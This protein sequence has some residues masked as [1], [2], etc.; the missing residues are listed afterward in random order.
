MRPNRY[1]FQKISKKLGF[2]NKAKLSQRIHIIHL[3]THTYKLKHIK[4]LLGRPKQT[5]LLKDRQMA[6]K[7]VK[8]CSISLI[9]RETQ[10][11]TTMTYY[12]TPVRMAIIKIST[13]NKCQRG[14]GEKG[15]LLYCWWECEL[16]QPLCKPVW[17]LLKKLKIDL[18]YDPAIPLL[19]T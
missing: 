1:P 9:I 11:R 16:T 10:I 8:R 17:K 7:H 4:L 3:D 18:P 14:C 13:N 19:G 15:T 2:K 5:F 12:L 6:N